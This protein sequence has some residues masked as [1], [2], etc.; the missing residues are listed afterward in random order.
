MTIVTGTLTNVMG[1]YP[2]GLPSMV[3]HR[4]IKKQVPF[5]DDQLPLSYAMQLY[6]MRWQDVY[7]TATHQGASGTSWQTR[8]AF[9]DL[10]KTSVSALSTAGKAAY[11]RAYEKLRKRIAGDSAD[12]LT[13]VRE[14]KQLSEMI[15]RRTHQVADLVDEVV[16]YGSARGNTSNRAAKHRKKSLDRISAIL[17]TP[18]QGVVRRTPALRRRQGA[19]TTPAQLLLELRWGWGPLVGDITNGLL[20]APKRL[21][22]KYSASAGYP[23]DFYRDYKSGIS[24]MEQE[25]KGQF[26]IKVGCHLELNNQLV[27]ELE[28]IGLTNFAQSLYETTPYSWLL[29]Y[30]VNLG[31]VISSWD[32]FLTGSVSGVYVTHFQ[33]GSERVLFVQNESLPTKYG[34]HY[35]RDRVHMNRITPGTIPLPKVVLQLELSPWRL[36]TMASL[37]VLKLKG[38]SDTFKNLHF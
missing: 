36:A 37:A 1:S 7:G 20:G 9:P 13:L 2:N 11:N 19:F 35:M 10:G 31:Q 5:V 34:W 30:F 21:L 28:R 14:Y 17:A 16:N 38:H 15:Y 33:K 23:L 32:D 22:V 25:V 3:V 6:R 29:D 18:P 24:R 12:L 26:R 4:T 8:D 27:T